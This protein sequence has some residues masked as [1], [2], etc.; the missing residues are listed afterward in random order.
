[1][2]QDD[3]ELEFIDLIEILDEGQHYSDE[4]TVQ[5]PHLYRCASHTLNLI[6]TSDV[7]AYFV[8]NQKNKNNLLFHSV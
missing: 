8:K 6:A 1:M 5:L 4:T 2:N 7:D 3:N